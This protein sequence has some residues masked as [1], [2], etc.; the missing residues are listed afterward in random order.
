METRA[1]YVLIGAFTL[2]GILGALGFF[3]WLAKVE[4]DKQYAYYDTLFTDATGLGQAGDVRYNGLLVGQVVDIELNEDDPSEVRIRLQIDAA[5]PVKTD[6]YAVLEYQGVTGVTFVALRGGSP[7]APLLR[8]SAP[9]RVP[10]IRAEKSAFQSLFDGGP[11]LIQKAIDLLEDVNEVVG[12]ENREAMNKILANLESASEKV[13]SV[14]GDVSGLTGELGGAATA[15]GNFTEVLDT[16]AGSADTTLKAAQETLETATGAIRRAETTIDNATGALAEAEQTFA[17]VNQLMAEKVPGLLDQIDATAA[18]AELAITDVGGQASQVVAKV[19]QIGD[20]AIARLAQAETTLAGIEGTLTQADATMQAIERASGSVDT[21]VTGEGAALVTDLRGTLAGADTAIQTATETLTAA[22]TTMANADR[23]MEEQVPGL[24]A[25]A[26]RT[27][28][29][30]EETITT[31]GAQ[32]ESVGAGVERASGLL[33]DRLAQAEGTLATL[34]STLTEA[35]A[36]LT[37]VRNTSEGM[38]ALIGTEARALVAEARATLANVDSAVSAAGTAIEQDLP[39]IL[40]DIRDSSASVQALVE[41]VRP[42]VTG[43]AAQLEGLGTR[44]ST[45]LDSANETFAAANE[46]LAAVTDAM[47]KADGALTAAEQ[48]F[49]GVNKVIDE[50]I[51]AIIADI[52]ATTSTLSASIGTAS[53]DLP[54]ITAEL[55]RAVGSAT[56]FVENLDRILV[57]NSGQI[58]EFMAGGLPEF[59]RFTQ[60]ARKVVSNLERL[61]AKIERDPARFLLGTQAPEFKR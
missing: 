5:V 8:A 19:D 23:V 25:R 48:T 6:T 47:D 32:A 13:D 36:T 59:V 33:A 27:L 56:S 17:G 49:A 35:N 42:D 38:G 18:A 28:A 52:R 4:V 54:E 20:L 39:Q 24:V 2:A 40:S 22:R 34:E 16:V 26:D 51:D 45:T 31:I 58:E 43:F 46:T 11:E 57:Q 53:A 9:G 29:T 1:N 55:R 15:L 41:E 12:P 44:A 37:S 61:T 50:D 14:L 60:E 3:L 10:V 21:L 30:A 7:D